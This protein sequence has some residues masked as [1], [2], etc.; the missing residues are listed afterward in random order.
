MYGSDE[1]LWGGLRTR[2][3]RMGRVRPRT[4]RLAAVGQRPEIVH[5]QLRLRPVQP[6][7][8][9]RLR[10]LAAG[11]PSVSRPARARA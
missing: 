9:P 1:F 4:I 5:R 11:R 3:E 8:G 2:L 10:G 7:L 6:A